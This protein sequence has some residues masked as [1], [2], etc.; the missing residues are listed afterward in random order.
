M[1]SCNKRWANMVVVVELKVLLLVFASWAMVD[2]LAD[3]SVLAMI[4]DLVLSLNV[5]INIG[6][7]GVP[8][9]I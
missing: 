1:Y 4:I 3:G 8:R 9:V 5:Y 7:T 2:S 6:R